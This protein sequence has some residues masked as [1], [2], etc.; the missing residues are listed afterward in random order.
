MLERLRN[1]V[2]RTPRELARF[3]AHLYFLHLYALLLRY[4]LAKLLLGTNHG[5]YL[6]VDHFD[7]GIVLAYKMN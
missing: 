4:T 6:S 2:T 7:W 1:N 5:E 3:P